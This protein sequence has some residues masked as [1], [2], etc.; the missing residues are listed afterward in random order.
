V[1]Q[2]V[3][4]IDYLESDLCLCNADIQLLVTDRRPPLEDPAV[5]GNNFY[6]RK[7]PFRPELIIAGRRT[8]R[9]IA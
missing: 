6:I 9:V 2:E 1:R 4:S 7:G 3:N 5:V 8:V